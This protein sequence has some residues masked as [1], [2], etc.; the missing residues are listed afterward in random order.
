MSRFNLQSLGFAILVLILALFGKQG[1]GETGFPV[2]SNVETTSLI[3]ETFSR[4]EDEV[5]PPP[6]NL[7]LTTATARSRNRI[8]FDAHPADGTPKISPPTIHAKAVAVSELGSS[9]P[10]FSEGYR[11]RWPI[12]SLT[13]LM[14]AVVAL[15][16]FDPA[17]IITISETAAGAVG[18]IGTFRAGDRFT[19]SDLIRA[20]LVGSVN[21]AAMALAESFDYEQFLDAMRTKAFAL[22]MNETTFADPMG[23]SVLNQSTAEDLT[24]LANFIATTHRIIFDLTALKGTIIT[25][26]GTGTKRPIAAT[27]LLAGTAGFVGG[28]TG[29]TSDAIGNLLSIFSNGTQEFVVIVLGTPDRFRETETLWSWTKK[30][31]SF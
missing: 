31:Q 21:D 19:V 7:S 11:N 15:D 9:L 30:V 1:S 28:K 25:E 2:T 22:G 23:I 27:N 26:Q 20:M 10:L 14:T 18:D 3:A 16:E 6:P 12:A 17:H 8:L 13:K 24:K 29:Y 4:I 5:P